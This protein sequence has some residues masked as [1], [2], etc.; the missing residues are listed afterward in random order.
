MDVVLVNPYPGGKGLNEATVLPPLGLGYIASVLEKHGHDVD[1]I[2]ANVEK[3]DSEKILSRIPQDSLLIGIH[4]NSFG[5][6]AVAEL[7][8]LLH[9]ERS[10][11][12]IVLGGPLPSAS[13]DMI[14]K[15]I[16]C[17]GVI[18]GE[19]EYAVLSL[20]TNMKEGRPAFDDNVA[21]A[22]YFDKSGH[23]KR[24]PV[25]RLEF[26]DDIPFPSFHL[27]PPLKSY[28]VRSRQSPSAALITSRGCSHQCIFCSKDIFERKVT[29][30]SAENVL[31][32]VDYLVDKYHIRQLDILDDNFMQKKSRVHEILDGLIARNYGLS[33][34]LQSGIR[35]EQVDEEILRKMRR[36]GIFKI[37]FGIESAD[38]DVLK[39]AKKKLNLDKVRQVVKLAKKCGLEVYG[40]FIIGLPGE[41]EKAFRKS[42]DFAKEAGFDIANF[43][44]AVPFVGTELFKMVQENGR[45]LLDTTKNISHGFYEGKVFYEYAGVKEEDVLR[46]YKQAYKEFYTIDR[47]IKILFKIRSVSELKWL[48]DS[49]LFVLRGLFNRH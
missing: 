33:I 32:E 9:K 20:I 1:V 39:I 29:F 19:G 26:L 28:K 37:A 15:E 48:L 18:R 38:E 16:D 7:C 49:T 40:F 45:F 25:Q 22:V 23:I 2:D 43:C 47:K 30:R 17:H 27:F 34:N 24:N 4:L 35:S 13:A 42:L 6:N 10:D 3:L 5:F 8:D 21:G 31:A 12:L 14:L 46:R 11:S 36:A 44:M 41:D